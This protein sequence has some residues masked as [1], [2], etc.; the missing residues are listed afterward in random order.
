MRETDRIDWGNI[1]KPE[2]MEVPYQVNQNGNYRRGWQK[3]VRGGMPK[4]SER[5]LLNVIEYGN[6]C[7]L[8]RGWSY[9]FIEEH[10]DEFKMLV[11][12]HE[13][14]KVFVHIPK[15]ESIEIS[16]EWDYKG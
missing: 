14:K 16:F 2:D 3:Y 15:D 6:H 9:D 8:P 4:R 13:G 11:N 5:T 1:P 12:E 7:T 10:D